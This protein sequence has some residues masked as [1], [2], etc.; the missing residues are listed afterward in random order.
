MAQNAA[1]PILGSDQPGNFYYMSPL[2]H[3]IFG[4]CEP[5]RNMMNAYIWEEGTADR[6]ADNIISCV[7]LD[8]M[9]SGL[10]N[11]DRPKLGH[12]VL[13]A[14]NCSGQNKNKAM[15]K[16]CMWLVEAGFVGKSHSYF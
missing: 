9:R 5:A 11:N 1:T 4:I 10:F 13:G 14:D 3:L 16:F 15:L 6:G 8:L 2:T 7:Y 12:L